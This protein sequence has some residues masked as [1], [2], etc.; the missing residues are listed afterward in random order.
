MLKIRFA[1]TGK[2][3]APSFRIVVTPSTSRPQGGRFLEVLGF[4]NS[5]LKEKK[6]DAER[7]KYWI[8]QG[9]Q[10]SDSVFNLLIKE[11]ILEGPK[12]KIKIK[13][14]ENSGDEAG[15]KEGKEEPTGNSGN[16]PEKASD[17]TGKKE[18]KPKEEKA[19]AEEKKEEG[20]VEAENT[21][22]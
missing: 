13:T 19:A 21:A 15:K 2:K 1:K 7:I 4:Y 16:Q 20:G 14:K 17:A 3:N 6:I 22:D 12:R 8:S 5:R 10:V 9:A 11:K 18:E